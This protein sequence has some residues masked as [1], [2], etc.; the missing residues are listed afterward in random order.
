V[1]SQWLL[2]SCTAPLAKKTK[3]GLD[4]LIIKQI[5]IFASGANSCDIKKGTP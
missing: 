3:A 1:L 2:I 4:V 5:E